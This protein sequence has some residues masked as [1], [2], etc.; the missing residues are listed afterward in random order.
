MS[1]INEV[2]LLKEKPS[3]INLMTAASSNSEV[4]QKKYPPALVKI[5]A[6]NVRTANVSGI[7][8]EWCTAKIVEKKKKNHPLLLT[9]HAGRRLGGLDLSPRNPDEP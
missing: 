2:I 5:T 6:C 8:A 1:Q 9:V 7:K 4:N 3:S